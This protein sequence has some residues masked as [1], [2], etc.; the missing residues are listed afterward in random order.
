ML[1]DF[2]RVS[3]ATCHNLASSGS[4]ILDEGVGWA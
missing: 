2:E 4:Q 3:A 1:T